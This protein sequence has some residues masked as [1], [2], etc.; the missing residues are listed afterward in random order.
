VL[1]IIV[2]GVLTCQTAQG[3][4]PGDVE[5]VLATTTSVRD[6]GLLEHVLPPFESTTGY[7]VKIIA[8]GSG[9]ALA[10]GQNGEADVL[11]VHDPDAERAFVDDGFG[12]ERV[13]L[14]SNQFVVVGP[15]R[16]EARI[17]GLS[18]VEAFQAIAATRSRF[19]SR[20]DRS[21][22]HTKEAGIWSLAGVVP[23]RPWYLESGQG[24]SATLQIANEF[25]A[26]ALTDI[27]TLLA[28]KSPLRLEILVQGDSTLHNP[29]H[30]LVPSPERFPWLNTQGATRLRRYLQS[31]PVQRT[32]A[33]YRRREFGRALF[34]PALS[35]EPQR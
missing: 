33:E 21:G 18:A 5:I 2:V 22:T 8:V 26:Y 12:S 35:A 4:K 28:H 20:A 13:P 29:Y 9:Q 11:I 7:R 19:V 32:I 15:G 10:L 31:A 24:M 14:M 16:D 6:A 3:Q 30:V 27:A 1:G 23:S 25:A 17:R 34:L